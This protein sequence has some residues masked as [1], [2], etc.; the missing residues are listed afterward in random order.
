LDEGE[1]LEFKATFI[2]PIPNNEKESLIKFLIEKQ[3]KTTNPKKINELNL[4]ISKIK[5]ES[6]KIVGI[7]KKLI[8]SSLKTIAAF[9]NTK[10]GT[11]I[12]G[13]KDD[14]KIFGL[15]QDYNTFKKE[16]TRDEFGKYFDSKVKEY[17]GDS[18]SSSL[19][20]KE[21]LKFPEGDI[22]IIK[23]L[24]SQEEVF[25]LK[26]ENGKKEESIYVRN[27]SSSEKLEGIELSKF[28]K[29]KFLKLVNQSDID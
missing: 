27:L 25:L 4:N 16:Q 17:F 1:K 28:I 24:Q 19:L 18:F 3:K 10:G 8:H 21:F 29:R 2:T 23:T 12:I 15:E 11:L 20:E 26:N 7:E 22:L 14:K 6:E 9:A 5:E 13:V